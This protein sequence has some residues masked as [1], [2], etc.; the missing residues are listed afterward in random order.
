MT[1]S[2]MKI[3][4]SRMVQTF[5]DLVSIDSPSRHERPMADH[6][7]NALRETGLS[8]SE[9]DAG[10]KIGGDCGNLFAVWK[11]DV[12]LPPLLF[13]AHM[14]T[15]QPANGKHAVLDENGTIHSSGDTVLGADDVSA[16]T[17]L[18]EAVR[19]IRESGQPHRSIELLFSVSE[20]TYCV[21][22]SAFDFSRITAQESYVLDY[23][24]AQG[25]AVVSA[26]TILHFQA[27]IFGKA[28]H[29]GFAPEIGV[30]AIAAA[31]RAI[32]RIPT[33]RIA[34]GLTL[35]IGK[36]QGGLLSNIVPDHCIVEGEIRGIGHE[37]AL[38]LAD[39]VRN[40]FQAASDELH[41]KLA[42]ACDCLV[43]A[44][45][46]CE[47]SSVVQRYFDV[48]RKRGFKTECVQ[49][50]GGSDNNVLAANGITGIVIPSA[51]HGCHSCCEYTTV[52]E[53]TQLAE[54]T[55]DLMLDMRA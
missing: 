10:G 15:V 22:A 1:V 8:V 9:D 33:G 51:M 27:E 23:E 29:A 36:I 34:E 47:T 24:G 42:F 7:T 5:L 21:G 11:S 17:A 28:A 54:I 43:R 55:M 50:L 6:L 49:T 35:N 3:N 16:I 41:A 39:R 44:Y 37:A 18:L 26:P 4:Q 45:R 19:T 2:K 12:D 38:A 32:A 31:A 46:I 52:D 53:L 30:N 25:R 20:E 14:D 13:C 48:C 40:A